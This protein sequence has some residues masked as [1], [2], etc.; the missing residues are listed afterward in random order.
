MNVAVSVDPD[1]KVTRAYSFAQLI[2]RCVYDASVQSHCRRGY[3]LPSW[4]MESPRSEPTSH[5]FN[6][7][8]YK[9]PC[10]VDGVNGKFPKT[11]IA[12]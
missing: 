8:I 10:W 7:F 12:L 3:L 2:A 9:L 5:D 4:G 1:K 11:K 6:S